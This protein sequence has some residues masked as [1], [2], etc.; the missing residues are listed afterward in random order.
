MKNKDVIS[1]SGGAV[2]FHSLWSAG[3]KAFDMGYHADVIIGNSAGA[4]GA[5]P[6]ALGYKDKSFH[7][8][9]LE[10]GASTSPT[11]FLDVIPINQKGKPTWRGLFNLITLQNS[12]GVQNIKR[13]F[14]QVVPK[15]AWEEFRTGDY[16][17]V[18][19]LSVNFHTGKRD[20]A[21][22]NNMCYEEGILRIAASCALPA[23]T[24]G[25]MI[26]SDLHYD[27]GIRDHSPAKKY[28]EENYNSIKRLVTFY[29]REQNFE[30]LNEAF[31]NGNIPNWFE[32]IYRA[33]TILNIETSKND[34]FWEKVHCDKFDI[35]LKQV[36]LKHYISNSYDVSN[37]SIMRE[38]SEL[39]TEQQ[40]TGFI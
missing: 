18:Y 40:L 16:P 20:L 4:L 32:V 31:A 24:Q 13:V 30:I 17:K 8:L 38:E 37:I 7:E 2:K 21:L 33:F 36:F 28:V 11:D 9:I 27:G 26:G 25:I 3:I 35:N 22:L 19:T 29:S 5:V 1:F 34:E 15:S 10:K 14:S 6:Y 23:L 39:I 12:I